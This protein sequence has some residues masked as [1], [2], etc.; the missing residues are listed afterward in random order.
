MPAS[1]GSRVNAII[2]RWLSTALHVH[3][4]LRRRACRGGDSGELKQHFP[5][6][7]QILAAAVKAKSA[8]CLGRHRGRQDHIPDI[9]LPLHSGDRAHVVTIEDAAS[10]S[11]NHEDVVRP[12]NQASQVGGAGSRAPKRQLLINSLRMRPD[13]KHHRRGAWRRSVRHAAGMNTGHE[14]SMTTHPSN[15]PRRSSRLES[16][17]AMASVNMPERIRPPADCVRISVIVQVSRI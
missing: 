10:C 7:M 13:R 16:M 11:S 4:A 9:H 3:P 8:S 12:G 5:E 6:M 1:D 14:G 2:P 17:V 15:T